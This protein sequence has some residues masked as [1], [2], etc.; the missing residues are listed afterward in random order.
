MTDTTQEREFVY[1]VWS[2]EHRGWW[3]AGGWGYTTRLAEAG[4]F[5]R[6]QAVDICRD[7]LPSAMQMRPPMFAELPVREDDLHAFME[8]G[9]FPAGVL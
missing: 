2:N 8:G 9:M 5:N 4:R 3:K 1:L 7:A 6:R